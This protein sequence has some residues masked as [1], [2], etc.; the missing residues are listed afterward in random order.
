AKNKIALSRRVATHR[1]VSVLLVWADGQ[2]GTSSEWHAE[3]TSRLQ[4]DKTR[5]ISHVPASAGHDW[6]F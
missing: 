3:G 1:L 6:D 2:I 5:R 4:N